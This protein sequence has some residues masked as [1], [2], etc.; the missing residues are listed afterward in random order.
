MNNFAYYFLIKK[1]NQMR[2]LY[3]YH[4]NEREVLRVLEE[5]LGWKNY[6]DKH[7]ESKYTAFDK[8]HFSNSALFV[9]EL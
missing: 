5:E 7:H 6:G 4:Y 1:I 3:Y 9:Q 8:N 2:I